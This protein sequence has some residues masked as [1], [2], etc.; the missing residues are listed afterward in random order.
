MQDVQSDRGLR[1]TKKAATRRAL[2]SA[3]R[4]LALENGLD[5]VTVEQVC[6][7]VGVSPRTF[8]N[9]FPTKEAAALGGDLELG[10]EESRATFVAGGPTGDLLADLLTLLDPSSA[11]EE[12]GRDEL[13]AAMELAT[14]EPRLLALQLGRF[15]GHE[16]EVAGLLAQRLDRPADDPACLTV[17]AVGLSLLRRAVLQWLAADDGSPLSN[18]LTRTREHTALVLAADPRPSRG[19]S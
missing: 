6:A 14:R 10:T 8:F 15:A 1:E 7:Q 17:A 11:M 19:A 3:T 9:Y 12:E 2:T 18:H 4:R 13:V 5:G 16:A